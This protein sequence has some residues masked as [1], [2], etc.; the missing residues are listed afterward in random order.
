VLRSIP[1]NWTDAGGADAFVVVARGR[2]LFRIPDLLEL[3]QR[4]RA[5]EAEHASVTVKKK[6]S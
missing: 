2:S 5:L 3:V 1:I 4:I 6:M